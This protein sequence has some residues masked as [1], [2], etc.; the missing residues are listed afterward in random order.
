MPRTLLAALLLLP[1]PAAA[2]EPI[3]PQ[4]AAERMKLPEGFR[5][6]VVAGE[7]TLI[8]PIAM[9]TD[10][11]GR[12]WIVES[13]SYPNWITDNKEG[14]DRILILDDPRGDGNYRCTVF[15]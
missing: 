6:R 4:R 13:H 1:S 7:P 12:L 15:W 5:V 14:K 10:D 11:R 9:T 2:E 8:K 3:S